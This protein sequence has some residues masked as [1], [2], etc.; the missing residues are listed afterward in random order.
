MTYSHVGYLARS[1]AA[2]ASIREDLE[3]EVVRFDF[4][5]QH[6]GNVVGDFKTATEASIMLAAQPPVHLSA[7][8]NPPE[9]WEEQVEKLAADAKASTDALLANTLIQTSGPTPD[10]AKAVEDY[11]NKHIE[12]MAPKPKRRRKKKK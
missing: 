10:T 5:E 6:P 3:R 11:I 9:S 8:T 12:S 2:I 7:L 4:N 1:R